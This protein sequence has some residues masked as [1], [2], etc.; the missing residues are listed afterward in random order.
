MVYKLEMLDND[1]DSEAYRFICGTNNGIHI[2]TVHK[3]TGEIKLNTRNN[4]LTGRVVNQMLVRGDMVIAFIYDYHKFK[5]I[6]IK[7]NQTSEFPWLKDT[8]I[9][10]TGLKWAPNFHPSENSIIFIRDPNGV[11][12]INTQTWHIQTLINICDQ[13]AKF[14]DLNLLEVVEQDD[15][16]ITVITVNK[17]DKFLV[18][19]TYSHM[20]KY[21]LQTASIRANCFK[22]ELIRKRL[23]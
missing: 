2:I 6:N 8:P 11:H 14:P 9:L 23:E 15:H 4:W 13:G 12:M 20:L 5:L 7:T 16:E 18:K 3:Q 10:C 1:F 19:R 21:C 17:A 22:S